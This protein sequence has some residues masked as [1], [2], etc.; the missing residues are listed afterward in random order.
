MKNIFLLVLD[1]VRRDFFF[2]TI[3]N[4][5]RELE[6]DF[7][8]FNNC[9]SLYTST[10]LS[11]YT[12]FYGDY[13]GKSKNENFPIQLKKNGYNIRSFC[14]GSIILAYPLKDSIQLNLNNQIPYR[15]DII[16]DLGINPKYVWNRS[17]FGN[18][19]E[20]YNGSADDV[21]NGIPE[22][23]KKS[24]SNINETKNFVF[25]HFWNTHHNYLINSHLENKIT[26]QSYKELG[27]NLIKRVMNKDL[28]EKFVKKVYTQR[29]YEIVDNYIREF[30]E[31]LKKNRIY[32]ES[33]IIITSDHGEGLGDIGKHF[34]KRFHNLYCYIKRSFYNNY[35]KII[36]KK[37]FRFLPKL[38][39]IYLSKWDFV[40]FFHSGGYEIQKEIPLLVKFPENKFGG[41]ICNEKVTLFDIIHTIDDCIGRKLKIYTRRGRSLRSLLK[42]DLHIEEYKIKDSIKTLVSSKQIF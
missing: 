23:W 22:I 18:S 27:I 19:L 10:C 37:G 7:V 36:S 20:D 21:K 12:I 9:Y 2:D 38:K 25:L 3:K 41:S 8:G 11:H 28:T 39:E 26:G 24:L 29:I 33:L 15:G 5:L 35:N 14:N 4:K 16:N 6:K 31:I 13:F 17:H 1:S 30:I 40:R 42:K 32:D 34:T